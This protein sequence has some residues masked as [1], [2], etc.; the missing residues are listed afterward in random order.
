M[1]LRAKELMAELCAG[2]GRRMWARERAKGRRDWG[3]GLGEGAAAEG[4]GAAAEE[5][6]ARQAR[7]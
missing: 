5:G 7:L 4:V 3:T 1:G 2:K 6:A